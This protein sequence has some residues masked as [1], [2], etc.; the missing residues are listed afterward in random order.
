MAQLQATVTSRDAEIVRLNRE[1]KAAR[2]DL[3]AAVRRMESY[4]MNKDDLTIQ[5]E[6]E[7]AEHVRLRPP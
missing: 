3:N 5:L 7:A 2:V 1:L 4:S 6:E